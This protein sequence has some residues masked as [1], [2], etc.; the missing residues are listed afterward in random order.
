MFLWAASC[1]SI[2][3]Q[4]YPQNNKAFRSRY[5]VVLVQSKES[6]ITEGQGHLQ[7][8]LPGMEMFWGGELSS[9]NS[10]NFTS[11]WSRIKINN[12]YGNK[13]EKAVVPHSSTL[14]W[15]VPWM[16]EPGRLQ[17]MG[18]LRV[19]HDWTT[20]L[21]L[22]TFMHRRRKWQP[23]PVFLAGESQGWESLVAWR[24]WARTESDTTEV[25]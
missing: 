14:A 9:H 3:R 19:R 22:F 16:E 20:S 17:S 18:S 11:N 13:L 7:C 10:S 4:T 12:I 25:T 21:S 2:G 24:L 5:S 1:I 6:F 23:T 8:F 15:K